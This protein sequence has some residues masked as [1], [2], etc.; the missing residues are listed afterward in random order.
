[1]KKKKKTKGVWLEPGGLRNG[2]KVDVGF[3]GQT[4]VRVYR[5]HP[6]AA[7]GDVGVPEGIGVNGTSTT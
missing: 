4:E 2:G 3:K 6:N 5:R 1:M 7:S